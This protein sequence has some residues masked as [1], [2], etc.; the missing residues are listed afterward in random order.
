MGK[1]LAICRYDLSKVISKNG[2][3]QEKTLT[4][5]VSKKFSQMR[6]LVMSAN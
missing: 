2:L 5:I 3:K 4:G 6:M 1:L